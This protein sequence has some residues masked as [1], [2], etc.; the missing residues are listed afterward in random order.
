MFEIK[1]IKEHSEKSENYEEN[2]GSNITYIV[3]NDKY[4]IDLDFSICNKDDYLE[5]IPS[6]LLQMLLWIKVAKFFNN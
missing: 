5:K 4:R 6:E 1:S 2:V 3:I